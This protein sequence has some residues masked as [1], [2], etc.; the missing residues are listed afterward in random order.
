V[1]YFVDNGFELIYE[2]V[3][4]SVCVLMKLTIFDVPIR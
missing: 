2:W 3:L 1:A 4:T